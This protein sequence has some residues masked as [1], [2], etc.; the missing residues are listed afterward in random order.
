MWDDDEDDD[1]EKRGRERDQ[2][3]YSQLSIMLLL[4]FR[5]S[6]P[7]LYFD[8]SDVRREINFSRTNDHQTVD[9]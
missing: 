9:T 3:D 8:C 7:L 5:K 2:K 6:N 1:V 4:L